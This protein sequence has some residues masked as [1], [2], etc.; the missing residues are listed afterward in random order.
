MGVLEY[1]PQRRFVHPYQ[2]V[3]G[4]KF[5]PGCIEEDITSL[6]RH[7]LFMEGNSLEKEQLIAIRISYLQQM[8]DGHSGSS[9]ANGWGSN[10]VLPQCAVLVLVSYLNVSNIHHQI[11]YFNFLFLCSFCL[12][13][14]EL[15]G[16]HLKYF[17]FPKRIHEHDSLYT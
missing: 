13:N 5:V 10:S 2:S 17:L 16:F 14:S 1:K 4:Y 3:I 15:P 6:A 9:G 8:G 11:F 7:L 12:L